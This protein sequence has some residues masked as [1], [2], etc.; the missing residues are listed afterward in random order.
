MYRFKL[1]CKI[2]IRPRVNVNFYSKYAFLS[3]K[4]RYLCFMAVPKL[5]GE[6]FLIAWGKNRSHIILIVSA[7]KVAVS[8]KRCPGA[9]RGW[10]CIGWVI[11]ARALGMLNILFSADLYAPLLNDEHECRLR[12][13]NKTRK[14]Y[15]AILRT[16]SSKLGT[17]YGARISFFITVTRNNPV[18]KNKTRRHSR[19]I[20]CSKL[21]F[22]YKSF[23]FLR[24]ICRWKAW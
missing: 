18:C 13:S 11:I 12:H 14:V 1:P 7:V 22:I 9:I 24:R 17:K 19:S 3:A 15:T 20:I 6:T 8:R 10:S 21:D 2:D 16:H 4:K 23:F 5:S